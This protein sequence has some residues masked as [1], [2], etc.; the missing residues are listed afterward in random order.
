MACY[1][2]DVYRPICVSNWRNV[3]K[4]FFLSV[5]LSVCMSVCLSVCMS[6]SPSFDNLH[7]LSHSKQPFISLFCFVFLVLLFFIA[8]EDV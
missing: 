8:N 1:V 6:V 5:C 4:R 3:I 2:F 7:S